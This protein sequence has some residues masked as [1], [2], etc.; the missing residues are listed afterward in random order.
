[1]FQFPI[2]RI[3][4]FF[5]I[6]IALADQ[7]RQ[8]E[9]MPLYTGILLA[10]SI[11]IAIFLHKQEIYGSLSLLTSFI[12]LGAFSMSIDWKGKRI[13]IPK[14]EIPYE[15]VITSPPVFK[16]DRYTCDLTTFSFQDNYKLK[17]YIK[18]DKKLHIGDSISC[19]SRWNIPRNIIL[20]PNFDYA[21]YLKRHG[22]AATTFIT[23][24]AT[25][26]DI[27]LSSTTTTVPKDSPSDNSTTVTEVS[28]SGITLY[29]LLLR[30]KLL[31]LLLPNHDT[32]VANQ[33]EALV[34]AMLLGDKSQLS[35]TTKDDFSAAGAAHILALSGLHISIL[36]SILGILLTRANQTFSTILQ[37]IFV[38]SFAILVGMPVSLLRVAIM[39]TLMHIAQLLGR[40]AYSLNTIFVAAFIILLFSPQSLYDIGFQLS[41]TAVFF[42]IAISRCFVSY[43]KRKES[44]RHGK[45]IH[46]LNILLA[47]FAAQLGTL[48]LILYHFGQFPVYFLATNLIIGGLATVILSLGLLTLAVSFV[49]FLFLP[50]QKALLFTAS[51]MNDFTHLIATLPYS[52]IHDLY[53]N[54]PQVIVCYIL[55]Y[56]LIKP[57]LP[58]KFAS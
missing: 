31:S 35:L 49:P 17:A 22:Y 13:S 41:F 24:P 57:F 28:V 7:L 40:P 50:C 52:T 8:Y 45:P 1:M 32:N 43:L 36:L 48:P 46:L 9:T 26:S 39:F 19:I 53:F 55:I 11:V 37:L 56:L 20:S 3:L 30:D 42:I 58:E 33:S 38:W 4:I 2:T 5:S 29:P 21:L 10:I 44:F 14:E 16:N 51:L 6:G 34:A 25:V 47:S 18:S 23:L 54:L 12:L 15:A 27:S